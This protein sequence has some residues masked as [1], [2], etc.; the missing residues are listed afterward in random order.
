MLLVLDNLAPV[1]EAAGTWNA[2]DRRPLSTW[3][4]AA[5]DTIG[6]R[7]PVGSRQ[8]ADQAGLSAPAHATM[9]AHS[10]MCQ[11]LTIPWSTKGSLRM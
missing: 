4:A 11:W 2:V 7:E 9:V 1:M 8:R 5:A 10:R 6:T 3:F